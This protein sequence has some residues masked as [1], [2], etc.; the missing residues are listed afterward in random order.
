MAKKQIVKEPPLSAAD[1]LVRKCSGI[2]R[3]RFLLILLSVHKLNLRKII[4]TIDLFQQKKFLALLKSKPNKDFTISVTTERGVTKTIKI[5]A[6]IKKIEDSIL[7]LKSSND[8]EY[9]KSV[10]KK[11]KC[12]ISEIDNFSEDSIGEYMRGDSVKQNWEKSAYK[13]FKK[14]NNESKKLL[15]D[16]AVAI[17]KYRN[18]HNLL[19]KHCYIK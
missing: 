3:A 9:C 12:L 1:K 4:G 2:K 16:V 7:K 15:K 11:V 6:A 17:R 13:E 14:K 8:K 19:L 10:Q 5:S 18:N